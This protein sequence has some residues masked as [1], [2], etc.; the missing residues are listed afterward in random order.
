MVY[1]DLKAE[2]RDL[3]DDPRGRYATDAYLV[4]K[5]NIKYRD[6]YTKLR[7]SGAEF[8]KAN[9]EVLNVKPGTGNLQ[10]S[11]VS[12]QALAL[13]LTPTI[14]EWKI[15]GTDPSTYVPANLTGRLLNVMPSARI[16]SWEWRAGNIFFDPAAIAVDIRIW[17]EFLAS[18]LANSDD[19]IVL[20]NLIGSVLTFWTASLVAT[21]RGNAAWEKTYKLNGDDACDDIMTLLQNEELPKV[22]RLG[23]MSRRPT[24]RQFMGPVSN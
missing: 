23:R 3:V 22:K 7:L 16:G 19:V 4:N 5:V 18:P 8:D 6:L 15:A 14:F 10:D 17:G 9:V 20:G 24:R 13:L 11:F 12:G 21:V 1:D 2:V